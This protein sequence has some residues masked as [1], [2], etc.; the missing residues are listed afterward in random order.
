MMG[1]YLLLENGCG[2]LGTGN[3]V[4]VEEPIEIELQDVIDAK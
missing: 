3:N 4:A 2:Q 1:E